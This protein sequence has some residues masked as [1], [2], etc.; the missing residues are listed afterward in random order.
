MI[1]EKDLNNLIKEAEA[2]DI[3]AQYNLALGYYNGEVIEQNYS[4][5]VEWFKGTSK[6]SPSI[7]IT[8]KI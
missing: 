3:T 2:G 5:A 6:N 4:K 8:N 7:A 1:D